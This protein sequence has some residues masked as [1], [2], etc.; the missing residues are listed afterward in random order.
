MSTHFFPGIKLLPED[1]TIDS[2]QAQEIRQELDRILV[3][4]LF[5]QSDR[6]GRFLRYTV[7]STLNG[8]AEWLKEYAIGTD[9]YDRKPPYHPSHDS[10][11]RTEA[12]RL[13][14]KL[15]EYYES[16]GKN[17]PVFI[18]FRLGSYVPVFRRNV[19][20][21]KSSPRQTEDVLL[22]EGAG[23]AVAVLPFTDLSGT[24]VSAPFARALANELVHVLTYADGIKV[25]SGAV[26]SQITSESGD[27]PAAATKLGLQGII[28]GTVQ[29]ENGR[30]RISI[31]VSDSAG[32]HFSSHRFE[33]QV[34][35][36]S[37]AQIQEQIASAF[38][39]RARPEQSH[40]R[41]RKASAGSLMLTVYPL[42]VQAETLLDEGSATDI[43]AA[44][45][46]FEDATRMAPMFARSFCGISRCHVEKALRGVPSSSTEVAQAKRA[47]LRAVELDSGM[48]D[49]CACLGSA[50]ALE[51]KWQEA[52]EQFQRALALGT[53][54]SCLRQY[55]I[56]LAALGRFEEGAQYLTTAQDIDPFSYRQKVARAKFF[57][58]SRRFEEGVRQLSAPLI[59]GPL[60]AETIFLLA[61]M[62]IE[63]GNPAEALRLAEQLRSHTGAH[64]TVKAATAELFALSGRQEA[65]QKMAAEFGLL[66][67]EQAMSHFRKALLSLALGQKEPAFS[68]LERAVADH[69]A[70][71][72]W[73][74]TDP[75]LDSIRE[76]PGFQSLAKQ[77]RG[78]AA[79]HG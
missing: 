79:L 37:L 4:P 58:I 7:E 9:V 45:L 64:S 34:Q 71:V 31:R 1:F 78:P 28:D 68:F 23:V 55:A 22:T 62:H 17:D 38:V 67:P 76:H 21:G 69:E 33:S 48:I 47:A 20:P 52:E 40:I 32:F 15:K 72:V 25:V 12:R 65:A 6:L 74:M 61:L 36:E 8:K 46:K 77:I 63:T 53:H 73:L 18:Y 49:S 57:H 5:E 60:P 54:P 59:H 2:V 11:V 10:I 50:L 3:D 42:I 24:S 75:R 16:S 13:R 14:S 43:Q 66:L 26:V 70:E 27:L 35:A 19:P 44:L 56:F 41:R 39:S 51:W 29:E 30:L